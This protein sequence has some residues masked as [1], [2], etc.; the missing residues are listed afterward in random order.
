M[1]ETSETSNCSRL[2][3]DFL[4]G[5][6]TAAHQVEGNNSFS[7]WWEFEQKGLLPVR[8]GNSC[9]QY[10]LYESDFDLAQAWGHNCHRLS[11]EWSRVEP[12]EGEWDDNAV[13]HYADVFAA[14]QKRNLEPIVT[15]NHF[16]LP[17][18]SQEEGGWTS[19][20]TPQKFGQFVERFVREAGQTVRF[21]LTINEP[22]VYVQQG[23]INKE[24]PPLE[25][26]A[27][28]HALRAMKNLSKAHKLAYSAV[29]RTVPES[30][31]GFAHSALEIQPCDPNKFSDRLSA[32]M[33]DYVLNEL[34][35]RMIGA[36]VNR[37]ENGQHNL[38]FI[39]INYYTRCCVKA[40]TFGPSLLVGQACKLNHHED[41]GIQS[42]IG[43][44][45]YPRGL[46]AVLERFSRYGVP[47]FVTENGI[48]SD[49][50][51][52]RCSFLTEHLKV[53]ADALAEG[54]NIIGYV[55]WSLIDNFEWHLGYEPRFGLVE[56]DFDSLDRRAKPSAELFARICQSKRVSS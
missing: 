35:F 10:A 30:M 2:P 49:D 18:W 5:A 32:S 17:A 28:S 4:L 13:S 20:D 8:S 11:V 16:T 29:K 50:D 6:A 14:L 51:N 31:V 22:T 34:F 43:W 44:E 26:N 7:D 19:A 33:R 41:S 47:M 21:W 3:E 36:S 38:D 12:S 23:Y 9:G 42:S 56:V 53:V 55:H 27:W 54:K 1:F 15:L 25:S 48:A 40:G 45:I 52:L 37:S 39:G 24:W 46:A